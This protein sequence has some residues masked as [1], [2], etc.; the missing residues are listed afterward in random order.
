MKM[1]KP[2]Y[3]IMWLKLR[4][5][6]LNMLLNNMMYSPDQKLVIKEVIVAMDNLERR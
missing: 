5:T 2:N 4:I 1:T 3:N 6:L